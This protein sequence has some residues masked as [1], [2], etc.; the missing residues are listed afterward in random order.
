MTK[1]MSKIVSP[2]N[3]STD[4]TRTRVCAEALSEI[5]GGIFGNL[6]VIDRFNHDQCL[7]GSRKKQSAPVLSARDSDE[8]LWALEPSTI[9]D[10]D[11]WL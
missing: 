11:V 8:L 4:A 6:P 7:E 5:C 3:A 9:G 1:T 2:R 10:C